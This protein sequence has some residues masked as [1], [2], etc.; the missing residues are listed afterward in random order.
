MEAGAGRVIFYGASPRGETV[1][2]VEWGDGRFGVAR[3][4]RPVDGLSWRETDLD[5]CVADFESLVAWSTRV[6][7]PAS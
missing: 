1:A 5:K 3:E 4:G 7:G 6:I 2:L